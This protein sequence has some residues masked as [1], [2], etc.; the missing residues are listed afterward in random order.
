[1]NREFVRMSLGGIRDRRR[2]AV[3]AERIGCFRQA[4]RALRDAETMNRSSCWTRSTRSAP[5]GVAI[6]ACAVEVPTQ[7]NHSFRDHH[8]DVSSICPT[9]LHRD[10]ERGRTIPPAARPHGGHPLRRLHA[11]EKIM[12]ARDYSGRQRERNGLGRTR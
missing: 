7:Q 9:C 1:M 11:D 3:I 2:S 10:R 5:T 12:I 6:V 4:V 8:L